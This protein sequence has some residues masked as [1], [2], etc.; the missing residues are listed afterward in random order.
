[1]AAKIIWTKSALADLDDI[2]NYIAKDSSFYAAA[3]VSEVRNASRSLDHFAARGHIVP[4]FQN[5]QIREIFIGGYRILYK[6]TRQRVY[7]LGIVHGTRNLVTLW[8]KGK[9]L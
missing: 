3:F 8:R 9:H 2:A 6:F 1:M 7:I 5:R 4:E